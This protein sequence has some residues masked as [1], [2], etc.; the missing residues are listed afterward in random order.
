MSAISPQSMQ[1]L[2]VLLAFFGAELDHNR[3]IFRA[4]ADHDLA[5]FSICIGSLAAAIR[6]DP[7]HGLNQRIRAAIEAAKH[8]NT[9]GME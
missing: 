4:A 2:R 6:R 8:E 5:A 7:R 1:D 9:G 3:H